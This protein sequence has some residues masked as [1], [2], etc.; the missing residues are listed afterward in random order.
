MDLIWHGHN[1]LRDRV[2]KK[3]NVANMKRL[4]S[5]KSTEYN[6]RWHKFFRVIPL[7]IF[8]NKSNGV[9]NL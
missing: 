4:V 5:L 9:G 1:G 6:V 2:A 3:Y 7:L 8:L